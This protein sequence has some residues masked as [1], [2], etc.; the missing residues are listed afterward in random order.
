MTGRSSLTL[1]PAYRRGAAN[2]FLI[3]AIASRAGAAFGEPVTAFDWTK[4]QWANVDRSIVYDCFASALPASGRPACV[5]N[6]AERC[7]TTPPRHQ[8]TVDIME[9]RMAEAVAWD[10]ILQ[11]QIELKS[12]SFNE[13]D[14]EFGERPGWIPTRDALLEAHAAW[15]SFRAAECGFVHA[16]NQGGTI[17]NV[18]APVCN[19]DMTAQR[20]IHVRDLGQE[21][22]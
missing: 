10:G 4:M 14:E 19:L 9:C 18:L 20:A 1:R 17:R 12:N 2:A 11:A 13:V 3:C 16:L 6:A 22:Q 15:T 8:T 21:P 7:E 5:G